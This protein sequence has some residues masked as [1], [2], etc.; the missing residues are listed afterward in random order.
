MALSKMATLTPESIRFLASYVLGPLMGVIRTLELSSL[1][2]RGSLL[3]LGLP[4]DEALAVEAFP[5]LPG[6]GLCL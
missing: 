6:D 3:S 4:A 5:F 2:I 1:D